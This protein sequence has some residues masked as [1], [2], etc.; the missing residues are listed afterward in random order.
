MELTEAVVSVVVAI[1][2][3][4]SVIVTGVIVPFIRAKTTRE[5]RALAYGIV[6]AAVGYAEQTG[7]V[8]ALDGPG[9]KR[10]AREWALTQFS[11]IGIDLDDRTIDG[12]IEDAVNK[13][14]ASLE[15][16]MTLEEA[17]AEFED[18]P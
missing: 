12:W 15:E 13:L 6:E 17:E 16:L 1:A 18:R 3:L 5:Q 7:L 9:K 10:R 4:L 11:A 2:G 8:E 14:G